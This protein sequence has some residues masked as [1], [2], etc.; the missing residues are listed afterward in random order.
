MRQFKADE[1]YRIT[2]LKRSTVRHYLEKGLIQADKNEENGYFTYSENAVVQA[3]IIREDRALDYEVDQVH[4]LS[5]LALS[6]RI[7]SL[8][9][10][11]NEYEQEIADLQMK[12]TLLKKHEEVLKNFKKLNVPFLKKGTLHLKA[13][14]LDFEDHR[15]EKEEEAVRCI[16]SFPYVHITSAGLLTKDDIL[17][18][19]GYE[20]NPER[21]AFP[22]LHPDLYMDLPAYD[23]VFMRTRVKDPLRIPSSLIQP[24]LDL[25]RK[26][27]REPVDSY[28]RAGINTMEQ[29]EEGM[30]Y[31]ISLRI[32]LK[33]ED[34]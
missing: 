2:G 28:L 12:V 11:I 20:Y 7:D 16:D 29:T 1:Y 6:K 27:K 22:P 31:Y 30:Q 26:E 15:K 33:P 24:M 23:Y 3:M 25:I 10:R 17:L 21:Q 4:S 18:T 14:Y 32:M 9:Q 13:F 19:P 5:T 8:D 34:K